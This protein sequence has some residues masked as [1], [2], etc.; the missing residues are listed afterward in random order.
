MLHFSP[1]R[2]RIKSMAG[3]NSL[4]SFTVWVL[5]ALTTGASAVVM[6]TVWLTKYLGGFDWN[7]EKVFNYHPLF[8]VIG[9]VFL[10]ANSALV[11]RVFRNSRKPLL[12]SVHGILHILALVF[13]I[14][15][16]VAVFKFHNLPT[17]NIPNM[18]SLHSWIGLAVVILF[19]MQWV[20]AF[21]AFVFPTL[22]DSLRASY[23]S[24]HRFWGAG[25]FVGSVAS[26]LLGLTEKNFFAGNYAKLPDAAKLSNCL[27]LVLSAYAI[28]IVYILG[29]E[30]FRRLE[31]A[32]TPERVELRQGG[33][34]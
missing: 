21:V 22:S 8:M 16:L 7:N 2:T 5:V 28:L 24:M 29:R 25:I 32:T 18:Y 20:I 4:K 30:D 14:V 17:H 9:M 1:I 31:S 13:S 3:D 23:L 15:G 6:T 33:D 19:C 12:K 26:C 27:G 11:Y 10:Y 34:K